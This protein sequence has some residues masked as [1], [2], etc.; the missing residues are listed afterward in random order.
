MSADTR[1]QYQRMLD[2]DEYY[3]NDPYLLELSAAGRVK[4]AAFNA[5]PYG[6]FEEQIA[7]LHDLVGS[8]AG[9]SLIAAPTFMDYGIHVHL[10]AYV[11][12]NAGSTFLDSAP[13]T[14]GDRS[15]AGPNCQFLAATHPTHPAD[16][17]IPDP[18]GAVMPFK[19]INRAA[20]I[21]IGD[22]CWIGGGSILLPGVSIG[23]GTTVGA[24]SV[25]TKNLPAN[26]VAAGNPARVLRTQ[27]RGA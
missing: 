13:I 11:F 22:D 6:A 17:L 2:G 3:G 14:I 16:R 4:V 27:A 12:I 10:G 5:V 23:D 8:V 19:V 1:T 9:P 25:V 7:A 21:T 20:P 15:W 26:V 24:G 18:D